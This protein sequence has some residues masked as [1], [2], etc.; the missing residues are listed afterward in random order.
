[1]F[2]SKGKRCTE[3]GKAPP[4]FRRCERGPTPRTEFETTRTGTARS[5]QGSFL[6]HSAM[7]HALQPIWFVGPIDKKSKTF[8]SPNRCAVLRSDDDSG[9]SVFLPPSQITEAREDQPGKPTHSENHCN[10]NQ[11]GAYATVTTNQPPCD[12][13]DNLSK[14]ISEISNI[15]HPLIKLLT[16]ILDKLNSTLS[17]PGRCRLVDFQSENIADENDDPLENG[18]RNYGSRMDGP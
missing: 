2:S 3:G 7:S 15:V 16:T 14:L 11:R 13:S 10:S 1:M 18:K 9:E 4:L 8:V 17:T 6:S 12:A 5:A